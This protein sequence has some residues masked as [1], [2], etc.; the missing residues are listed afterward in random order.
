MDES[1]R[2]FTE[3]HRE[4]GVFLVVPHFAVT[5]VPAGFHCRDDR[6]PWRWGCGRLSGLF[7]GA[8]FQLPKLKAVSTW[9]KN[10]WKDLFHSQFICNFVCD[11]STFTLLNDYLVYLLHVSACVKMI[12]NDTLILL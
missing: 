8:D 2:K 7:P 6:E 9:E 1:A 4:S 10:M 3:N 12:K 5:G 11:F